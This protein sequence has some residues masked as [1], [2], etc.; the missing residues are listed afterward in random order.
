VA[1]FAEAGV[2]VD[3]I[4]FDVRNRVEVARY[5]ARLLAAARRVDVVVLHKPAQPP[6]LL[7]SLAAVNPRIVGDVD[8][9][10]WVAAGG[11]QTTAGSYAQRFAAAVGV[12]RAVVAGSEFLAEEIGQRFAPRSAPTVIRPSVVELGPDAT[13]RGATGPVVAGWIGQPTNYRDFGPDVLDALRALVADGTVR[14]QVVSNLDPG[15]DGVGAELV[16]WSAAGEADAVAGFDIGLMPLNDDPRSRGRCGYKAIQCLAAGVPV[17]ASPVGAAPELVG[18][19]QRG[20]LAGGVDGWVS[21][22][23]ELAGQ[24]ELRRSLGA[25]GR[26]WAAGQA[27]VTAS[28]RRW[29]EVFGQ[30]TR[31]G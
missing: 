15:W 25:A 31:P 12:A 2:R 30:V 9:A 11:V 5:G 22:L 18:A 6:A 13:V 16:P 10:V 8:D 24:P 20:R 4:A 21:A 27:T 28:A 1:P 23:R 19:D 17:V 14:V 26:E 29:V 3:T 7:R